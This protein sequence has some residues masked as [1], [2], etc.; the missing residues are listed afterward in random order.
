MNSYFSRVTYH[1]LLTGV[2]LR[3]ENLALIGQLEHERD[4]ATAADMAKTRFLAAASHDLRQPV[5]ALG[6]LS[7]S[8]AAVAERGDVRRRRAPRRSAAA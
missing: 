1:T 3:F 2:K 8:L 7:A 4:R 5:H 6:L